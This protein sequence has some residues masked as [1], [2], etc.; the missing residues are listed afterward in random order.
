MI[1]QFSIQN[2][3][4]KLQSTELNIQREYIQNLFLSYFYQQP[5]SDKI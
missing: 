5:E 1:S 2:I 4:K 3:A